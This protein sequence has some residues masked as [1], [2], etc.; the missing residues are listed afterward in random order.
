MTIKH[1][2]E[3]EGMDGSVGGILAAPAWG[4]SRTYLKPDAVACDCNL[5]TPMVG[6]EIGWSSEVCGP[7]G[8]FY[9]V[10]NN[11]N[12]AFHKLKGKNWHPRL[13]SYLHTWTCTH[14]VHIQEHAHIHRVH[15]LQPHRHSLTHK[16]KSKSR[17]YQMFVQNT[18][19]NWEFVPYASS[20]D[21]YNT[22]LHN[23]T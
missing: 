7:P 10:V 15:T 1:I 16:S 19:A 8:L 11:K 21:L 17:C 22:L 2:P 23:T 5:G 3:A 20:F 6:W 12:T 4:G 18:T 14:K 13:S 9:V